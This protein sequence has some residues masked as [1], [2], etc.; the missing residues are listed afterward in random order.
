[1]KIRFLNICFSTSIFMPSGSKASF[2]QGGERTGGLFRK[3]LAFPEKTVKRNIVPVLLLCG[4]IGDGQTVASD[5]RFAD[6]LSG[7]E[8][9]RCSALQVSN[10]RDHR[11]KT[12]LLKGDIH[13]TAVSFSL[14]KSGQIETSVQDILHASD[15]KQLQRLIKK[16]EERAFEKTLCEKQLRLKTPPD[17]CYG[18]PDLRDRADTHCLNLKIQ[19]VSLSSLSKALK[20]RQVSAICRRRLEFFKKILLYRQKDALLKKAPVP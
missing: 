13:Y 18:F 5:T 4:L 3:I 9:K 14:E 7:C 1:M 17:S 16:G 12:A 20:T 2:L 11:F 6:M 10:V 8:G 19:N 15:L